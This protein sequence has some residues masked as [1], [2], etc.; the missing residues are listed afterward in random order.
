MNGMIEQ[1]LWALGVA[2]AVTAL[3]TPL[4]RALCNRRAVETAT[5]S[6]LGGIAIAGGVFAP[7]FALPF[8]TDH[9]M[10]LLEVGG[11]RALS[12]VFGAC[13]IL[14]LGVY[15]DV[16]SARPIVKLAVQVLVALTMWHLGTRIDVITNPFGG[17]LVLAP[18]VSFTLTTVWIVAI[19][20]AV[21]LIDGL[22]GL[23]GGIALIVVVTLFAL[24]WMDGQALLCVATAAIAGALL[25]FL[26]YNFEPATIR[27]GDSGSLFLGFL[28]AVISI[29]TTSKQTTMWAF[30]LPI[31][32][33]GVPIFDTVLAVGRRLWQGRSIFGRDQ[34]HVHHR[35]V[36]AGYSPRGAVLLLYAISIVLAVVSWTLRATQDLAQAILM[37]IVGATVCAL[38]HGLGWHHRFRPKRSSM[39]SKPVSQGWQG[40][41]PS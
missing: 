9:S 15:D 41:D 16:R 6:R 25:A 24:G 40:V 36:R 32:A 31:I 37:G 34:D 26:S 10:D 3:L 17:R 14:A 4:V 19:T 5:I 20:N 8:L 1:S 13:V 21:N 28:L 22:D 2:L 38:V 12:L 33:L 11:T 27:M 23:A 18:W 7:L 35:L 39:R 29:E 30:A